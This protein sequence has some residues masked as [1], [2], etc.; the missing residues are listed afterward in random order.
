MKRIL[1][2]IC[3]IVFV[4]G[5]L[6]AS[7]AAA[8]SK[9]TSI[10]LDLASASEEELEEALQLINEELNSRGSGTGTGNESG[11][12]N[13]L[14]KTITNSDGVSLTVLSMKQTKGSSYSKADD[15]KI[16][17][18]LELQIENNTNKAVSINSTFGF[19]AI[20]DDYSVDYSFSAD[21]NTDNALST[22]DLKPG[23]KLKGWKGFEVPENWHEIIMTFE[24]DTSFLGGGE[25]IEVF[26]YNDK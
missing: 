22:T 9:V 7:I 6:L 16:F 21:M 12:R 5:T 25:E 15:G 11:S 13:D 20:C 4:L 8:D 23:R 1:M 10:H 17:V 26:I 2:V 24:P 18:L 3:T 19:E 14:G